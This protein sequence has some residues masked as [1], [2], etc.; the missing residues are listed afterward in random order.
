MGMDVYGNAPTTKEGEYF[1]RNIWGWH[2]LAV[3]VQTLAP[4]ITRPCVN[5]HSNDGD[6]LDAEGATKLADALEAAIA[7]GRAGSACQIA[8]ESEGVETPVHSMIKTSFGISAK[9]RPVEIADL[10][11]FATFLRGSGGFRIC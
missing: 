10:R 1:R 8:N 2:P 4:A 6:G 11:E 3:V 5:W 9:N 7:D